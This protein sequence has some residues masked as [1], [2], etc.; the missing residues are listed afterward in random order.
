ME[1]GTAISLTIGAALSAGW[2]KTFSDATKSTGILSGAISTLN[3]KIR[4]TKDETEKAKLQTYSGTLR[5]LSR[6][7]DQTARSFSAVFSILKNAFFAASSLTSAFIGAT[8]ATANWGDGLAKTAE[9][10]GMFDKEGTANVEMLQKIQWAALQANITTENLSKYLDDMT[11]RIAAAKTGSG[12]AATALQ[13]LGL[14]ATALSNM[15]ADEQ[16]ELLVKSLERVENRVERTRLIG[17]LFGEE[18]SRTLPNL[19]ARGWSQI[20]A[21]IDEAS[22][23]I[24][25]GN[26]RI[27]SSSL[28][29]ETE[30]KKLS[31][32]ASGLI[33]EGLLS[34]LPTVAEAF[35]RVS[36]AL[37]DNKG[38]ILE[39]MAAFSS[40]A[41]TIVPA[42]A[43]ILSKTIEFTATV[44]AIKPL[45]STVAVA[46]S[47]LGAVMTAVK[48][49]TLATN[50]V[51][52][53]QKT[54]FSARA[55]AIAAEIALTNT[56]TA[57]TKAAAAAQGFFTTTIVAGVSW[58]G[59]HAL[60]LGKNAAMWTFSTAKIL[61]TA[62]A[63]WIA[64]GAL[65][66]WT[67]LTK[68][69]AVAQGFF[70]TTIIA[71]VSWL[72]SHVAALGIVKTATLAWTAITKAAAA[73]QWALN[74]ALTANPIGLVITAV[75]ALAAGF[76]LLWN[77]CDTFR[78]GVLAVCSAVGDAFTWLWDGLSSGAGAAW[79]F[80]SSAA[81]SAWTA[82]TDGAAA[83]WN[84]LK[85]I[86]GK[87]IDI[88]K[89]V[90]EYSPLGLAIKAGSAI[91]GFFSGDSV[92]EEET[93][94]LT[95]RVLDV[96]KSPDVPAA[97]TPITAVVDAF[98]ART[99]P[100]T[101]A[102]PLPLGK[103]S[104][105]ITPTSGQR[106]DAAR[107][108]NVVNDN[109]TQN[110]TIVQQPGENAESLAQRIAKIIAGDY[111][112]AAA[113]AI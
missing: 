66:A 76:V 41:K 107:T 92:K 30:M 24:V 67:A 35:K 14:S 71:G 87:I 33:H 25:H 13:R 21:D 44:A 86:C 82:I 99:K 15:G 70:T 37:A 81:S 98:D 3:A 97:R 36:L 39:A 19:V 65:T 59:A 93:H 51:L 69:A 88:F 43:E 1:T 105:Q 85:N 61:A 29:W 54:I 42:A 101:P 102:Q 94:P 7:A 83:A 58:L 17:Q 104:A 12:E 4:A 90:M 34:F 6:Q 103:I 56:W 72:G 49:A 8:S 40:L 23:H 96:P 78:E 22:A 5:A 77:N 110:F 75:A 84:T 73:A 68:A 50:A 9:R 63:Q 79:E 53:V 113:A 89:K 28:A 48:A 10:L 18:A 64:S 11:R 16:F 100:A 108:Q 60:A 91:A 74:V 80:V 112:S 109:S 52:L 47:A 26:T 2:I 45:V 32:T 38:K 27:V 31:A 57:T 46:L 106:S 55:I 20:S 95:A 111:T 62:T